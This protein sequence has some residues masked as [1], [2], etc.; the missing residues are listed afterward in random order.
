MAY[1][2]VNAEWPCASNDLP[3]LQ[4]KEAITA[5]KRLYR[6]AMKRRCPWRFAETSGRRYGGMDQPCVWFINPERGWWILVHNLSH[7]LSR[8]LHPGQ[9]P[10]STQHAFLER[11]LIA[12]VVGS[13]WLTGGLARP[14]VD[15]P[16]QD[17]RAIRA[18]RVA[19]RLAAW[20]A[21]RRRADRA[22]AGLRRKAAYYAKA[23][24]R[25][26]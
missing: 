5:T 17:R 11:T 25:A 21:K 18:A 23:L 9:K 14:A 1:E 10:H 13:G 15:R 12:H 2:H 16:P 24:E 22:I 6:L 7:H 3:A 20:Q 26:A 19:A 4:Y 8:Q